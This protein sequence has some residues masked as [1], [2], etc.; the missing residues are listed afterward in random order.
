MNKKLVE[1]MFGDIS[2]ID[3][4]YGESELQDNWPPISIGQ[5]TSFFFKFQNK[6]VFCSGE[7]SVISMTRKCD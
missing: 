6:K 2:S 1:I 3:I 7:M 5:V 4:E